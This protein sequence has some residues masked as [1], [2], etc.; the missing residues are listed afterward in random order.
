MNPFR[1]WNR[2]WFAPISARPL[3]AF[4]ILFGLLVLANLAIVSFD[5]DYWLTDTG[6][7]QGT[8][9]REI[10]GPLRYS[11]LQW[12]DDPVSIRL[13]FGAS[14][15]VAVLFTVGW[16][17][18]IM[19]VVLYLAMLSIHHRNIVTNCGPDTLILIMMFYAMLSPCGA[20]FSLDARRTARKRGTLADPLIVPWAQRL[21]QLQLSLIYFNT[22]VLKCNGGTWLG[23]TALHF[24]LNNTEVGRSQLMWLV[25]YP[26]VINLLTYVALASEFALAALLWFRPTRAWA[27]IVGLGLHAGVLFTVNVPIFGEVMTACYLVFLAPDELDSFLRFMNPRSWLRHKGHSPLPLATVPGRVDLASGLAGRHQLDPTLNRTRATIESS[28]HD[29]DG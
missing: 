8:E 4:R 25:E 19:G 17:T 22:A 10:A 21:I 26:I 14:A 29:R 13:F 18:R 9:A 11:P 20:A 28:D 16:H 1:P 15:V 23:G 5:L 3:G 27:A 7:L 12:V 24:V 6:L 2:F